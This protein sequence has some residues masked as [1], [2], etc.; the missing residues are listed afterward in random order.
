MS[1]GPEGLQEKSTTPEGLES[2]LNDTE[3]FTSIR[4]AILIALTLPVTTCTVERSF[5]TMKRVKTWLSST[6]SDS[7]LSELCMMSAHRMMVS[8]NKKKII[9]KVISKFGQTP[10]RKAYADSFAR[11]WLIN[12]TVTILRELMLV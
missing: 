9:Q 7:R 6:M 1:Y 3:L 5:S 10:R 2:L 4:Q 8:E 11:Q 12:Y